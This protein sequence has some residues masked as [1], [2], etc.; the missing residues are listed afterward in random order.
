[1]DGLLRPGEVRL[2]KRQ[3]G[4]MHVLGQIGQ[5]FVACVLV[6]EGGS[7]LVMLD[8]HAADERIRLEALQ[9]AAAPDAD[10]DALKSKACRT[11]KN[12]L[13]HMI[14][15][16]SST[17]ELAALP[18]AAAV[19]PVLVGAALADNAAVAALASG[20]GQVAPK[21]VWQQLAAGAGLFDRAAALLDTGMDAVV[22][23]ADSAAAAIA[24]I[25]AIAAVPASRRGVRI[26][27]SV[28]AAEP[29]LLERLAAAV[30]LLVLDGPPPASLHVALTAAAATTRVAI[31]NSDAA[32]PE[33][34]TTVVPAARIALGGGAAKD[35]PGAVDLAAAVAARLRSDRP[36]GLFSTIVADE[37][38]VALG[39]CFSSAESIRASLAS[40]E[41]VYHSRTRGLWH[42]GLTSGATQK[43]RRIDWD[44]DADALRFTV[45]QRPPGF[46]HLN[47][48]TCFG[49]DVGFTRLYSTL[50]ERSAAAPSGSYTKRLFED[51]ALLSAK[52][53][54]EADELCT[55]SEPE[56]I[57]WEAAD[58]IYFALT[59]C[60]ASGVSLADVE[61]HLDLR[62][63]KISRRPG[64]A[65]PQFVSKDS[66]AP[67]SAPASAPAP[68]RA[69]AEIEPFTMRVHSKKTAS[70]ADLAALLKRP[71]I[72][73]DEIM[74]RVKPIVESVRARGNAA[75]VEF[76]SKFDGVTIDAESIVERAP[77]DPRKMELDPNVKAAIDLAYD[78]VF[79]FH[80]AQ[81]D[82]E[83]LVVETMPGVVCSR[84]VR[85]IERVGLYIPGGTAVLPS[86]TLMLGV[87]AKVAGCTEIVLATPPRKDGTIA[88]EIMY[89][90]AK[91]G[92]T[93]VLK[94][95][96]AQA[97]AAM[98]YGTETVPK[99]DK[100]CGPGNQY[101]TAAKM[102]CQSD[103]SALL[104]IDMPAGPSELLVVADAAADIRYAVSDLLSQAEHGVDSQVV[105]VAVGFAQ[106]DL[107]A[108]Q[109][110]LKRQ[111]SVLPRADIVK[112]SLS[113]SYVL[114]VDSMDEAIAFSNEYAPEHLILNVDNARSYVPRIV[115]A[116]SVFL[117]P[118]SPESCGD[119]ASGTNHTL[120]TYGY[121]R[122][123][124]GVNT[125]TFLKHITTQE[126]TKEG[127]D[128]IGDCVT[129]LA[130]V[131]A[132][133]AHRNAVAIRLADIRRR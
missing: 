23:V 74:A 92:A 73:T 129:T 41:G 81:L 82:R 66:P 2:G 113:K 115:S 131:E 67:A 71:I 8:Q 21:A 40:L 30:S 79:K 27:A 55:A 114:V 17:S 89:V 5:R 76:T 112:V 6:T 28:A 108:L 10:P 44:C 64:N 124:S 32:A 14:F 50:I 105:L 125:H 72:K 103:S 49:A 123:Y 48:R 29:A 11:P 93:A 101:V 20:A 62:S 58:L 127:L 111:A 25:E 47:T 116:G 15:E 19:F 60:V 126:L 54:E 118:F 109:A 91:I 26:P 13:A 84:V 104:S 120:P 107:D 53:R 88:P 128:R 78:N 122:M 110:E 59:K 42:K 119:Y 57:A 106:S 1:M 43:L 33:G 133:E 83:P 45:V 37:H 90:A 18:A 16:F 102:I 24:A 34:C 31:T 51:P 94:A 87:P 75:L 97:V 80:D 56:E 9:R 117:G 68:A 96:G 132:L 35:A 52:I 65:K 99:V 61:R 36:D 4:Q 69:P 3:L 100:I 130:E 22:A 98:A 85:P 70:T 77:F 39:L 12:F 46:C 38:G 95:G 63:K 121:A 86:S 7:M